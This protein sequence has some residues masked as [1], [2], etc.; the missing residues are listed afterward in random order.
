VWGVTNQGWNFLPGNENGTTPFNGIISTIDT[1]AWSN[2]ALSPSG[3]D[4]NLGF[5][6]N[7]GPGGD[8]ANFA[9]YQWQGLVNAGWPLPD[10]YIVHIAWPSQ[11]V[12]A[13]DTTTASAAWTTHGV[14]LWQP[15]LTA[16]QEP[17]YALAPFARQITYRA[18]QALLAGGKTPR[19]LGLQWNQ[20]EA[21]AGNANPVSIQDAP[22]NYSSLF[23]GLFAAVGTRYPVQF[24]KPLSTA[25][26]A[27]VLSQMQTVFANLA[28][29]DPAHLSVI[30]VS[31]VSSTIFSGG[32]LGGGDGAVHYNLDTHQWFAQQAIGTCLQ[33]AN[34]G[35]RIT[36]LPS[37]P[38][39]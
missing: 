12:D 27:T 31:Q 32:V 8:A 14:N 7:A 33:Q 19:V 1:V 26:G 3:P 38:P 17:S 25:Y 16:S 5:N 29:T 36:S 15:A 21:E 20:W 6:T 18:L 24:V 30:D 23:N 37:S 28:A 2:F 10:L 11:G 35:V 34:C 9:A 4:M 13:A 22:N 39:N